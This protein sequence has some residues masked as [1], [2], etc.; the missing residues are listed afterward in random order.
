MIW[1]FKRLLALALACAASE[2]R[3]WT[4]EANSTAGHNAS[5]DPGQIVALCWQ[6]R[7]DAP[8]EQ[9]WRESHRLPA[10]W[11][12]TAMGGETVR[13]AP[14][15]ATLR[16]GALVV[17]AQALAGAYRIEG[18]WLADGSEQAEA[19][20]ALIVTVKAR[21]KLDIS[22]RERSNVIV[23]GETYTAE[24]LA[25]NDGNIPLEVSAAGAAPYSTAIDF[26]PSRF[27]LAPG[28]TQRVKAL[29]ATEP[30]LF[31]RAL[32]PLS[33]TLT[34]STGVTAQATALAELFPAPVAEQAGRW[35]ARLETRLVQQADGRTLAQA[36]LAGAT[37]FEG[38][39]ELTY[40]LR[41]R[42]EKNGG[43]FDE[44]EAYRLAYRGP[45]WAWAAGNST[46]TLS[47]LTARAQYGSGAQVN[48]HS[49]A[50]W[51]GGAF[52]MRSREAAT[53][54]QQVG[55][56]AAFEPGRH[57]TISVQALEKAPGYAQAFSGRRTATL[58]TLA[59]YAPRPAFHAEAEIGFSPLR[60]GATG[61]PFG[62]RGEV[63]QRSEQGAAYEVLAE[64][65]GEAFFGA[66]RGAHVLAATGTFPLS[67]AFDAR[68]QYRSQSLL[69]SHS[70]PGETRLTNE[71]SY[72]SAGVAWHLHESQLTADLRHAERSFGFT[73]VATRQA[74]SAIAFSGQRRLGAFILS[75][76][77][78]L[79]R[80][81]VRQETARNAGLQRLQHMLLW[82][83]T[84]RGNLAL[85]LSTGNDPYSPEAGRTR[86]LG[87]SGA[88]RLGSNLALSGQLG[89][90]LHD[91]R[92]ARR[93]SFAYI[94]AD[95]NLPRRQT[96]GLKIAWS[97]AHTE[98]ARGPSL[99]LSYSRPLGVPGPVFS[100]R[101]SVSG[102][103]RDASSGQPV[104]RAVVNL[105][106]TSA[107]TDAKGAFAFHNLQPGDY[108]LSVE[109]KSL[110]P[111]RLLEN[112]LPLALRLGEKEKRTLA[113]TAE[114]ASRLGVQVVA[115]EPDL[116]GADAVKIA[117]L[118]ITLRNQETGAELHE[119]TDHT[120]K[121]TFASIAPGTWQARLAA[122]ALPPRYQIRD[123]APSVNV[124]GASHLEVTLALRYD[125][126]S[127]RWIAAA[128]P[129]GA[130]R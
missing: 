47:P 64:T 106:G 53:T 15:Q 130:A 100:R 122:A 71:E 78:E 93:R 90:N 39:R 115:E 30:T 24:I 120:G 34:T 6:L 70:I 99:A 56:F 57:L 16:F 29:V 98:N 28:A 3:A 76:G 20:A 102:T 52:A 12:L 112:P 110:G 119:L 65:Y 62:A 23:A 97:G 13:V 95:Y 21:E 1:C 32:A 42:G 75:T 4:L 125:A 14:G 88:I 61:S 50:G 43:L 96:L 58:S 63:R 92:E 109:G 87:V 46:Y 81:T 74:E 10:G 45:R 26:S 128:E 9:V 41:S 117:G 72:H 51:S 35:P 44:P 54:G 104:S 101:S 59:R 73:S 60:A 18:R 85:N 2:L 94:Q 79:G 68:A 91:A 38:G 31:R 107:L 8:G 89:E 83:P 82:M 108:Q 121:A 36:A 126:P 113:L 33:I 67:K 40:F 69:E 11:R 27:T 55:G 77:A 19:S 123:P 80:V 7:S 124:T 48:Y 37:T 127:I 129:T 25:T 5:A 49:P 103:L 111:D 86:S 66:L 105:N 84:S 17:P 22:V 116:P 118:A 114:K